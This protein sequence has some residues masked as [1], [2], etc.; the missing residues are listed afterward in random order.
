MTGKIFC[1]NVNYKA[2]E[3]D[4]KE[5]FSQFGQVMAVRICTD[6]VTRKPRGIAYIEMRTQAEAD[7][8]I[9]GLHDR[10]FMGR[11][12]LVYPAKPLAETR[13]NV[14]R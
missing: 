3:T 9:A 13:Q 12:L 10:L 11:T 2:I 14:E 8:A 4:L 7:A 6:Y 5:L 1:S